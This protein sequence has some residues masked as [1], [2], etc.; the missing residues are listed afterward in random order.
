MKSPIS[1]S[2][3]K[4]YEKH[5]D[6]IITK[7]LQCKELCPYLSLTFLL[8]FLA[9]Q[10]TMNTLTSKKFLV[11]QH[12]VFDKQTTMYDNEVISQNIYYN[13]I[14]HLESEYNNMVS[15][16]EVINNIMKNQYIAGDSIDTHID[17][18]EVINFIQTFDENILSH[19]VNSADL[20]K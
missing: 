8:L 4:E 14:K 15:I 17:E 11:V 5:T 7:L 1:K 20:T 3:I 12:A 9:K 10:Q 13:I 18:N 19:I 2:M 16:A 6:E